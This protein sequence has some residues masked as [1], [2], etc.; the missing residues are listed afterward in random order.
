MRLGGLLQREPVLNSDE[1]LSPGQPFHRPL[2]D[3]G[4]SDQM[5]PQPFHIGVNIITL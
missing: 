4:L 5:G 2:Q 1:N 3:R